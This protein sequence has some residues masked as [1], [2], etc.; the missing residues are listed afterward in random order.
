MGVETMATNRNGGAPTVVDVPFVASVV[1]DCALAVYPVFRIGTLTG[2]IAV[3]FINGG[4]GQ[5]ARVEITQDGTGNRT[6]TWD[7]AV[8]AG[9]ADLPLP[10]ASTAANKHDVFGVSINTTR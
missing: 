6:I 8:C 7:S 3:S 9:S 10:S 2:N 1:L 5:Q 4:N